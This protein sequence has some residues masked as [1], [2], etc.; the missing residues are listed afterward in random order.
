MVELER[1]RVLFLWT[2]PRAVST[3]FERAFMQRADTQVLHEPFTAAYYYGPERGS[4]R[5][6]AEA[7]RPE[8]SYA[9]ITAQVLA[10]CERPLRFVKDM[11]YCIDGAVELDALGPLAEVRHSFLIRHPARTV[12]SL[13]RMSLD[14]ARA[15]W[16][17]FDPAEI[18]YAG[19][20]RLYRAL[21]A[22]GE[23]PV[24]VDADRLLAEPEGTMQAYCEAHGLE[25]EPSMLRWEPGEVEAWKAWK[26]W[27]DHA[28]QSA[29]LQRRAP[30]PLPTP[31]PELR[32]QVDEALP[33]YQALLAHALG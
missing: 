12:P 1:P 25:F 31:S 19:L 29:G 8:C 22:R 20:L 21:E 3:A 4:A 32:S 18:G 30:R 2:V 11:A 10:P 6:Q 17:Y 23:Q 16:T 5:Y 28:E 9:A 33:A 13:H 26:G 15:G 14:T 7:V 24:V 27:H